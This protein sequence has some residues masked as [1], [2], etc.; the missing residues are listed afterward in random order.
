MQVAA[1]VVKDGPITLAGHLVAQALVVVVVTFMKKVA[2]LLAQ[3][4]A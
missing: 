2:T 4:L 3:V 1:E